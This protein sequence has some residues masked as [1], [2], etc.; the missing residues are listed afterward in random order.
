MNRVLIALSLS[1]ALACSSASTFAGQP[2]TT[3]QSDQFKFEISYPPT[4]APASL[5]RNA[6][7]VIYR[8]GG[9]EASVI[10]VHVARFTG[11]KSELMERIRTNTDKYVEQAKSRLPD[12]SMVSHGETYLGSQ[13]AY[14]YNIR[15]TV[16]SFE[17]EGETFARQIFCLRGDYMYQLKLEMTP[18]SK[19]TE[20][21]FRAIAASFN[22]R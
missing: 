19:Q 20:A 1:V 2:V 13:P 17:F 14:V 16:R 15:Y 6:V 5:S 12:A 22:F 11:N 9:Q 21:E 8:L 10:S 7:F 3:F 4:W 18:P